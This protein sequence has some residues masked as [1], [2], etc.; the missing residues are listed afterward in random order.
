[1]DIE[2]IKKKLNS[3]EEKLKGKKVTI[4]AVTKYHGREIYDICQQVGLTHVGENRAQEVRD[5]FS[6]DLVNKLKLHFISPIQ[7]KNLKYIQDKIYSYDALCDEKLLLPLAKNRK[8][9]LPV[10]IQINPTLEKQKSGLLANQYENILNFA[11]KVLKIRNLKLEGI[12]AMG[13]TP[14]NNYHR[15]I[16]EYDRDLHEAFS[17]TQKIF[18][19]LQKDLGISLNR[20]SLGMSDDF[21]IAIDYG[22]TEIRLGHILWQE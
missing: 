6:I 10:L 19:N 8:S 9:P 1:M 12:L 7:L 18:Q 16:Y 17:L 4:V 21:D 11:Q 20:L 5:K 14:R 15:G 3:I 2:K 13:P 22:A